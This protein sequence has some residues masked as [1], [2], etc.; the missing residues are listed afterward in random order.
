MKAFLSI[1]LLLIARSVSADASAVCSDAT[2][3]SPPSVCYLPRGSCVGGQ[4]DYQPVECRTGQT[5]SN[6]QCTASPI[7][8]MVRLTAA[9]YKYS[10]EVFAADAVAGEVTLTNV[11]KRPL[12]VSAAASLNIRVVSLKRDGQP[13]A[14]VFFHQESDPD[15][16]AAASGALVTLRPGGS[17]RFV[18]VLAD[19]A[20]AAPWVRRAFWRLARGRYSVRFAYHFQGH[21]RGATPVFR[22]LLTSTELTFDVE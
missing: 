10:E 8:M 9:R 5:C 11:S 6:G 4:C 16:D 13:V 12:A 17:A 20:P 14:P 19:E 7:R 2:C 22:G 3:H 1:A 15:L 18:I 21:A